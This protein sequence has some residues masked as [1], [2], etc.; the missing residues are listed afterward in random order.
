MDRSWYS[1]TIL[2][3]SG[4]RRTLMF[5]VKK[6]KFL[7]IEVAKDMDPKAFGAFPSAT[8]GAG[9]VPSQRMF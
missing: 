8:A 6:D 4:D 2:L 7:V 1:A 5:E 3:E 9:N